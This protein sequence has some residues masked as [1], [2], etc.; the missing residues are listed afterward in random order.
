ML[1]ALL[2]FVSFEYEEV[3]TLLETNFISFS[4]APFIKKLGLVI[5][6]PSE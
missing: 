6:N 3:H 4:F 1:I 5:S 2:D